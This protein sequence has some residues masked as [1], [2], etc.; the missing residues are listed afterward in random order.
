MSKIMEKIFSVVYAAC[1]LMLFYALYQFVSQPKE[2]QFQQ[3]RQKLYY[4]YVPPNISRSAAEVVWADSSEEIG[5]LC[6]IPGAYGCRIKDAEGERI[7]APRPRNFN[8]LPAL[9]TLGHEFLH[10]L[11]A[12]H[13]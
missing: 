9:Q 11:G 13:D 3:P 7:I 12:Q 10:T 8:D 6:D 1:I 5:K 4:K 2:T